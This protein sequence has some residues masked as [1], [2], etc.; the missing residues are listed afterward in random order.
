MVQILAYVCFWV[1]PCAMVTC[2][3]CRSKVKSTITAPEVRWAWFRF[4]ASWCWILSIV[5]V[6]WLVL[7]L[8]WYGGFAEE[9]ADGPDVD[10]LDAM[11]A[12]N[13]ARILYQDEWWRLVTAMLCHA[14]LQ[15]LIGNLLIQLRL[16][17]VLET[18]WGPTLWISIYVLTGAFGTICSCVFLPDNLSVGSSGALCGLMGAWVPYICATWN[19][20]LPKDIKLRNGQL[21]LATTSVVLLIPISFMPLTDFAA[22]MGGLVFG[23]TLSMA[24]FAGKLQTR[25]WRIATRAVGVSSSAALLGVSLW[26]LLERTAPDK[27]LLHP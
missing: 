4:L 25:S 20:T 5:Q 22:H 27:R 13:A 16:G 19:Q 12:K 7:V 1:C 23:M 17:M 15:H 11:G 24:I 18:L 8:L 21:I 3:C 26:W 9:G 10:A 6:V 2:G 14:G